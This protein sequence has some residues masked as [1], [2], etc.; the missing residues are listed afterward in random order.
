M[1]K[2]QWKKSLCDLVIKYRFC[3]FEQRPIMEKCPQ[4][5]TSKNV[6]KNGWYIG[7]DKLQ[8]KYNH[9]KR[10][11]RYKCKNCKENKE[12]DYNF[13]T[14]LKS[15]SPD[16]TERRLAM[17]MYL[18]GLT[19]RQIGNQLGWTH[20]SVMA[21]VKKYK[22][23][24]PSKRNKLSCDMIEEEAMEL[25][26]NRSENKRFYLQ[27]METPRG[28]VVCLSQKEKRPKYGHDGKVY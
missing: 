24:L 27:L 14:N 16:N 17:I 13:T 6:V 23:L 26:V 2:K 3:I 15:T 8:K 21:W 20:A 25:R 19:F 11:Q 18:A 5:K 9:K 28:T 10:K 4:C 7:R 1:S 22:K 12:K